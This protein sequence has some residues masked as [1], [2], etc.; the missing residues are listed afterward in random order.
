M[1]TIVAALDQIKKS[2]PKV[3]SRPVIEEI[4]TELGYTWRERELDPAT[5]IALCIQQVMHGNVPC[6]DVADLVHDDFT[7]SAFCQAR[8]RLPLRVFQTLLELTTQ[9]IAPR[10]GKQEHLWLGHR[11]FH[12][13]GS[14]FSMPDTAEL[15]E[16]F[17]QPTG[18]TPGC[19]FPVAHILTMFSA[20][21]GFMLE[22]IAAPLYTS[23][24]ADLPQMHQRLRP[25]DVVIADTAFG[26]YT[27]LCLLKQK[28][29]HGVFPS[30]QKRIVDF[31]RNR[32][33]IREGTSNAAPGVVRSRWIKALGWR[34]QVVEYF[35]PLQKPAWISQ[36][37]YDALPQSI[38]VRELR[39]V[40]RLPG[41]GRKRLTI[42][43]TLTDGAKY[44]PEELVELLRLRWGIETNLGH[45]KTTM[46][47]DVLHCKTEAGVRKE[48]AVFCLVYNLVRLGMLEAAGRQKVP[49]QRISFAN[50]L[51]WMRSARP[52]NRMRKIKVN[53]HRPNRA[54][55]R[56]KKRRPKPYDLMRKPR[57]ALRKALKTRGKS[58]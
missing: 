48:L 15:Q 22:A 30:H 3:L 43:T 44:P 19:G 58:A 14:T 54:E 25:G 16:T 11:T 27:H 26:T 47:M 2:P 33:F 39:R 9:A 20:S 49:V 8:S 56:C 6:S 52:G 45:L 1:A 4:C 36:E 13:D 7:G 53:P 40:V 37:Q 23:D 28:K 41:R 38:I 35:K 12:L 5:T 55:P 10:I 57:Q 24:L 17:G 46:K 21:T 42:V 51:S 50:T 29:L 34:D 31:R 18:Q 32:P